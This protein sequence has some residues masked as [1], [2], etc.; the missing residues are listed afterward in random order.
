MIRSNVTSNMLRTIGYD[1]GKRTLEVEFHNGRR[2]VYSGVD[3]HTHFKFVNADSVGDFFHKN[4]KNKFKHQE[5]AP[6]KNTKAAYEEPE[7]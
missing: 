6:L 7:S 2:Y 1:A 3:S 5:L 4:V